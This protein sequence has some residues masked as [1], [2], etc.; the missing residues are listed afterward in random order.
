M[1]T[2]VAYAFEAA[3]HCPGCTR[4]RAQHMVLDHTHPYATGRSD[5]DAHGIEHDLV[6][7]EG[8]L[9][10]PVFS[11]DEIQPDDSCDDCRAHLKETL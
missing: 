11:T 1:T 4:E 5:V 6:D 9:I 7:R 10:H 2:I 8:N 3:L